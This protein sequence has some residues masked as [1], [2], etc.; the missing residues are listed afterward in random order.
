VSATFL[1]LAPGDAHRVLDFM[2][3]LYA[4]DSL[5]YDLERARA[6]C[7]WLLANPEFGG[8]W[9]IQS[10]GVDAG[11]LIVT[12]CVS[13]EFR[14]RFALLDEL[15]LDAAFRG[16]GLGADAVEFA[17]AWA[18]ARGFSA[19]RLETVQ[20]NLPAQSLYRKCGFILHDR[21][22]MTKWLE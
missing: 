7:E 12:V 20:D 8:I 4:H 14:G 1:P 5:P 19:I 17:A 11:Y 13:I 18:R 21:H 2:R 3:G 9:L 22:L 6:V 16:Q 10:G 15:Y